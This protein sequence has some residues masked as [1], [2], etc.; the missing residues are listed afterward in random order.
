[1]I[2]GQ[3]QLGGQRSGELSDS[4]VD[5]QDYADRLAE[6]LTARGLS[7]L[8]YGLRVAVGAE[9]VVTKI[10]KH[11]ERAP[12]SP[13]LPEFHAWLKRATTTRSV[14][15]QMGLDGPAAT[16]RDLVAILAR[17]EPLLEDADRYYNG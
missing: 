2:A 16:D 3:E 9:D 12:V 5:V 8:E 11:G 15:E 13:E 17:L 6:K 4:E 14:Q 10:A 1:M 7:V